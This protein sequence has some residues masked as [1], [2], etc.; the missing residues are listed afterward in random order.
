MDATVNVTLA[1]L[2][3][4]AVVS[5]NWKIGRLNFGIEYS[6]ISEIMTDLYQAILF[7]SLN[8][9]PNFSGK[10]CCSGCKC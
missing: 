9:I 5:F 8:K 4:H 7:Y 6:L 2:N 1:V 10:K 3:L